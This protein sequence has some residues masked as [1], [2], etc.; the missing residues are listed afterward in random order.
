LRE[1]THR[2]R[3]MAMVHEKLYQSG[4]LARVDFGDY[5][6]GLLNYLWRAHGGAAEHIHLTLDLA[7]VMLAV[8]AAVPCGLILNELAG[9]ALK[10][11][12]NERSA[13]QVVISLQR[14]TEDRVRLSVRDD[15]IGLPPGFDWRQSRSLGLRLVQ[16][17]AGQL[18][19]AVEVHSKAGTE[20]T[21][22]FPGAIHDSQEHHSDR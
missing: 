8:N 2:V 4:D 11:A 13:G 14:D 9:N 1:V 12:F 22:T 17:L 10:H 20:F 5:T 18:H 7:P 16:M 6:Q 21:L 3:S 15:G 19:A